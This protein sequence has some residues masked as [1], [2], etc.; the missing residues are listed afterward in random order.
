MSVQNVKG[1]RPMKFLPWVLCALLG[2]AVGFLGAR[3][4]HPDQ[5]F[6]ISNVGAAVLDTKTGQLCNPMTRE[7]DRISTVPLCYDLYKQ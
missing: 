5:R 3:S 6:V 2:A 7:P 1:L 4:S